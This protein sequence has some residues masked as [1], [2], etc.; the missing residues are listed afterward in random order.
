MK[1]FKVIIFVLLV[2]GVVVTLWHAAPEPLLPDRQTTEVQP[3][4]PKRLSSP[5]ELLRKD[6]GFLLQSD[7]LEVSYE[8]K[9]VDIKLLG[10]IRTEGDLAAI[11]GISTES[12]RVTV[13]HGFADGSVLDAII[14]NSIMISNEGKVELIPLYEDEKSQ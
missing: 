1:I 8:V 13:G 5:T 12:Q 3:W 4:S 6:S 14:G 9:K 10:I 2:G 11:V 7:V